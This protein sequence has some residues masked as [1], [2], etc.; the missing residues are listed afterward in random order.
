MAD[1]GK[2]SGRCYNLVLVKEKRETKA[3]EHG[4]VEVRETKEG[5]RTT[6]DN[7][8]NETRARFSEGLREGEESKSRFMTKEGRGG[9][10]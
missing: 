4:G 1:A 2:R 6:S 3:N 5:L 9:K 8:A 10:K 7:E